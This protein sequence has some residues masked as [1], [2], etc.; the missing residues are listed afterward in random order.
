MLARSNRGQQ[1]VPAAIR[2]NAVG[3]VDRKTEGLFSRVCVLCLTFGVVWVD[4]ACVVTTF[5]CG[6]L[7]GDSES[8]YEYRTF[9]PPP[10]TM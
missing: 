8:V 1:S 7:K 4:S 2:L 5:C 6:L 9:H 3:G 10:L